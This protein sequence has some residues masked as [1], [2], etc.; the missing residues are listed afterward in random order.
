M[1]HTECCCFKCGKMV[2]AT[3]EPDCACED[4]PIFD[5]E[6]CGAC[7]KKSFCEVPAYPELYE[8]P[9]EAPHPDLAR[10]YASVDAFTDAMK[11]RLK[12]K[13]KAG[14]TGWDGEHPEE[15]LCDQI[16]MDATLIGVGDPN[17]N[18]FQRAIDIGNR[19]MFI[20]HR[21]THGKDG[22]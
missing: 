20:W 2:D 4:G 14:Y 3:S 5:A 9:P 7:P 12:E 11:S 1:K 10:L 13:F 8:P 19:S 16:C 18:D 15:D 17:G 21:R 6:A 22:H